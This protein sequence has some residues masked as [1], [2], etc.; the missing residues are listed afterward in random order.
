[1]SSRDPFFYGEV[2]H[3]TVSSRDPFFYGIACVDCM[4]CITYTE[5]IY[6]VDYAAY[7]KCSASNDLL[8][9]PILIIPVLGMESPQ[10]DPRPPTLPTTTQACP[11]AT[12]EEPAY[13]LLILRRDDIQISPELRC[14]RHPTISRHHP[15][16]LFLTSCWNSHPG[17]SYL[18]ILSITLGLITHHRAGQYF[19][20]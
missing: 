17:R 12:S 9:F 14:I 18:A 16:M 11:E 15:S 8:S 4:D 19:A 5:R 10:R 2:K 20:T 7:S 1:M 13:N 3:I 6:C